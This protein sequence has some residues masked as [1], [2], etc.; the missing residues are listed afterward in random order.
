MDRLI[1]ARDRSDASSASSADSSCSTSL[2]SEHAPALVRAAL[3]EVGELGAV[4]DDAIL[5]ASEL[6]TNAVV[7]S[8]GSAAHDL[9]VRAVLSGNSC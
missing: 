4:R 6:V 1:A 9:H 5:I 3:R 2:C 8:Q 7:Q